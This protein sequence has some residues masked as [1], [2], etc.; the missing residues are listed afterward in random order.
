MFDNFQ[1]QF[2]SRFFVQHAPAKHHLIELIKAHN[3]DLAEFCENK[4]R[5]QLNII[6][7]VKN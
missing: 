2:K 5:K 1:K 6:L 7:K 4:Q 3:L